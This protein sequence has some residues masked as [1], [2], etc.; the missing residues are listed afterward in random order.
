MTG[1]ASNGLKQTPVRRYASVSERNS[2]IDNLFS[3]FSHNIFREGGGERIAKSWGGPLIAKVPLE[4]AVAGCGDEGTP[5]VLR[6]PNSESAKAFMQA[7]D[8]TVRT[9]S[10]FATEGDGVLKNFNYGFE[11]LPVEDV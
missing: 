3:I 1:H 2:G 5:A 6:Y 11:E 7:A 10:M 4:P 9:L 8:A